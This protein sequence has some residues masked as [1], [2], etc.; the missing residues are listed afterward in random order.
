MAVSLTLHDVGT[1]CH[2]E[3][4]YRRMREWPE[5]LW[6]QIRWA[7]EYRLCFELWTPYN[8]LALSLCAYPSTPIHFLDGQSSTK[9][10]FMVHAV[11]RPEKLPFIFSARIPIGMKHRCSCSL[12]THSGS[13]MQDA[14]G[15]QNRQVKQMIA[16][17]FLYGNLHVGQLRGADEA[18]GISNCA[19]CGTW[20]C[21]F[22]ATGPAGGRLPRPS[23]AHF[24]RAL[25][26]LCTWSRGHFNRQPPTL[27][28]G[29]DPS[30]PCPH[31]PRGGL[32]TRPP[33]T[34]LL[35]SLPMGLLLEDSNQHSR[36]EKMAKKGQG[37]CAVRKCGGSRHLI[38][39]VLRQPTDQV[40][41]LS[42]LQKTPSLRP[43]CL[44][45]ISHCNL[46]G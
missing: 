19:H 10:C 20:G 6:K 32:T 9:L 25:Q 29:S 4:G 33:L 45:A 42:H 12:T 31:K 15:H 38:S 11:I 23:E 39:R 30:R 24:N 14:A 8:G 43:K 13:V 1:I 44:R 26:L 22:S 35:P 2:L 36:P 41:R 18:D 27:E 5:S 3:E 28:F 17:C 16:G 40:A 37:M 21:M 34:L 7:V 46:I